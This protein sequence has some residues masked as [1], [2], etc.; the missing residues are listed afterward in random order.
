MDHIYWIIKTT[1]AANFC[2]RITSQAA[3]LAYGYD[4]RETFLNIF[5]LVFHVNHGGDG[6]KNV[7]K[8][9]TLNAG[10]GEGGAT[11]HTFS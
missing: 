8:Q 4:F 6:N 11:S 2:A 5:I 9:Y 3:G 1:T 7:G 10:W